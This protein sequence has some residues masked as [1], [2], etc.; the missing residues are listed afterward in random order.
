MP[1]PVTHFEIIGKDA[2]KTQEYY[3]NLFGWP[4]DAN[5]PQEY[6]MVQPQDGKGT[7][8]GI[9]A[10]PGGQPRVTF[11]VEVDNPQAY[12]DKA[13]SLGGKVVVPVTA[14]E[15]VTFAMFADPDGNVIGLAKA[16]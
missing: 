13:V 8:G 10:E 7:G 1:N 14:L 5:N 3:R 16:D 12:L 9:G 4:V 2:N 15:D 11:Y 6:G